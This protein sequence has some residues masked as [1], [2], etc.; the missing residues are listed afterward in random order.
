MNGI[1]GQFPPLRS[2]ILNA[3]ENMSLPVMTFN[4][5][6]RRAHVL[7]EPIDVC[8]I[9]EPECRVGMAEAVDRPFPVHAVK[10]KARLCKH[11]IEGFH[12]DDRFSVLVTENVVVQLRMMAAFSKA[13]KKTLGKGLADDGS[14]AGLSLFETEQG[15]RA[16]FSVMQAVI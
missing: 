8:A 3:L 15:P 13:F 6:N 9:L 4:C 1:A 10:L 11:R 14:L 5:L 7:L 16:M 12:V 2:F